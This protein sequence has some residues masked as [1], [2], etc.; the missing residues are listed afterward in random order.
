MNS[1]ELREY[2]RR[3][4]LEE[5]K[6]H[7]LRKQAALERIKQLRAEQKEKQNGIDIGQRIPGQ[8]HKSHSVTQAQ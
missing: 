8:W 3:L 4:N 2:I 7:E 5:A 6:K 1:N